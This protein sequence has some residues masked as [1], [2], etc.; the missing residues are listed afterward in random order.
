[1]PL[2]ESLVKG[3]LPE[4]GTAILEAVPL[5][6]IRAGGLLLATTIGG[7]LALLLVMIGV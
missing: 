1:M 6:G 3:P 5:Q 2:P 7:P 4:A